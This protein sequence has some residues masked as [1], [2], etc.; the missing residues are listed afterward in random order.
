MGQG[1]VR[2]PPSGRRTREKARTLLCAAFVHALRE[3]AFTQARA[4]RSLGVQPYTLRRWLKRQT[5]L[6]VEAVLQSV[7]LSAPF[8]RCLAALERKSRREA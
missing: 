1:N 7:K 3:S 8:V 6:N 5:S 4:A 2:R